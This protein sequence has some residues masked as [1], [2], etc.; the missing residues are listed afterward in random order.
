MKKNI[1]FQ[2]PDHLYI[3]SLPYFWKSTIVLGEIVYNTIFQSEISNHSETVFL[4]KSSSTIKRLLEMIKFIR[5]HHL[6]QYCL[7]ICISH[8]IIFFW[9]LIYV[10]IQKQY[11]RSII[12]FLQYKFFNKNILKLHCLILFIVLFYSL[13]IFIHCS[14]LFIVPFYSLFF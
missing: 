8:D 7:A 1:V 10:K 9:P 13:F 12:I 4:L 3:D 14:I 5:S 11:T 6:S 2:E